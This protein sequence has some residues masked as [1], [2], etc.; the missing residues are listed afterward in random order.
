MTFS[1]DLG[2]VSLHPS[3][4]YQKEGNPRQPPGWMTSLVGLQCMC[5]VRPGC[6]LSAEGVSNPH[7]RQEPRSVEAEAKKGAEEAWMTDGAKSH[8]DWC[9][10]QPKPEEQHS[11]QKEMWEQRPVARNGWMPWCQ[12]R[13]R[14]HFQ[15]QK[16]SIPAGFESSQWTPSGT[17]FKRRTDEAAKR[18]YEDQIVLT[19]KKQWGC[20]F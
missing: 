1:V 4:P 20:C 13:D 19:L 6:Q 9:Q 2:R 18:I 15:R 12:H 8:E 5:S 10:D 17:R 14:A 16:S 11:C 3:K 7:W